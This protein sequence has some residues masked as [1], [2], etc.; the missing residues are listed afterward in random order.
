MSY[1]SAFTLCRGDYLHAHSLDIPGEKVLEFGQ[2]LRRRFSLAHDLGDVFFAIES[3]GIKGAYPFKF[4]DEN[5]R[6]ITI[7]KV[8]DKLD[9]RREEDNL[10]NWYLD[11]AVEISAPGHVIQWARDAHASI[12]SAATQTLTVE[13]ASPHTEKANFYVDV[14][15]Q[16]YRLAGFRYEPYKPIDDISYFNTYTTDKSVTYQLHNGVF[17]QCKP[18]DLYPSRLGHFIKRAHAIAKQYRECLGKDGNGSQDGTARL[19]VRVKYASAA[20]ALKNVSQEALTA[21]VV[22][23]PNRTWW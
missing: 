5:E 12:L 17:A 19:E 20:T 6:A 10:C 2:M 22:V 21:M 3:R 9:M 1:E 16:L 13:T 14:N 11:I 18:N 23:L 15:S 8:F 7:G 4:D